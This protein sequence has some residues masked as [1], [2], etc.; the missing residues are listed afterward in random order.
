MERAVGPAA[1]GDRRPDTLT[2]AT[3]TLQMTEPAADHR[4]ATAERNIEA[5]LDAAESLLE[6][7]GRLTMVAVAKE[8]GVSRV[9]VYAHFATREPL[10]EAVVERAVRRTTSALDAVEPERGPPPEALQRV[11]EVG[12][13]DLDR[14][15]AIAQAASELLTPETLR[16][17]HEAAHRRLRELVDRGRRSGD[18]RT[19]VPADWLV[20]AF[21][22]LIHAAGDDVRAGRMRADAA[23]SALGATMQDLFGGTIHREKRSLQ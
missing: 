7:G 10:L 12:W 8:A 2:L 19:D 3:V 17:T 23:L 22:A 21:H 4:R 18:F 6:R 14:N 20:S 11:I 16:R 9:T 1:P 5:I 15:N 13:R